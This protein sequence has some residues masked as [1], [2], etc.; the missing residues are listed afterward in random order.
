MFFVVV[1][2]AITK[3]IYLIRTNLNV[4]LV[5]C[6]FRLQN[7]SCWCS[8]WKDDYIGH[9][10]T[11]NKTF[12]IYNSKF[13]HVKMNLEYCS[14]IL[15]PNHKL[16]LFLNTFIASDIYV[17]IMKREQIHSCKVQL[18]IYPAKIH[19]NAHTYHHLW[20]AFSKIEVCYLQRSYKTNRWN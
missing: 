5:T 9:T 1:L 13:V 20:L 7:K 15:D 16:S 3:S 11:C 17:Y 14:F 4:P 12:H 2:F 6:D 19:K 18:S 8:L 10:N